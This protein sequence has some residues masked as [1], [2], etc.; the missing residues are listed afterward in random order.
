MSITLPE[1]LVI[2]LIH[3]FSDF[4]LQSDEQAKNKSKSN[5]ALTQHVATY[6]LVWFFFANAYTIVTQNYNMEFFAL[7]TFGCHWVTDYFT[8]RLNSKLYAK[9]DIHNFFVSIG[10]DQYLHFAQLFITF[11]LLKNAG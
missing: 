4:V 1:I 2:L 5:A 3:W 8:S 9:G 7:I 11:Y 10:A 6:S